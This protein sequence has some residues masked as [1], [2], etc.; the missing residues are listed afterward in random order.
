VVAAVI[1]RVAHAGREIP[2]AERAAATLA[3]MSPGSVPRSRGTPRDGARGRDPE[4]V[5]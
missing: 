3:M 4:N 2:R 1:W 5:R